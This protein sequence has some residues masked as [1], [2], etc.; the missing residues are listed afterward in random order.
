MKEEN[1]SSRGLSRVVLTIIFC[2]PVPLKLPLL[3][4]PHFAQPV[5]LAFL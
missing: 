3:F 2:S 4:L 5:S 1:G